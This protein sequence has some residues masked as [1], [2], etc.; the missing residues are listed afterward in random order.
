MANQSP[1]PGKRE[2]GYC[3]A[4]MVRDGTIV[5]LGTGSTVL[6]AMERLS[7]RIR[8]GFSVQ[9]V[10]TSYEAEIRARRFGIPLT[11][12]DEHPGIEVAI[13]GADQVDHELRMIKGRGAAH[14]REKCVAAAAAELIIVV[15]GSKLVTRLDAPV[16]IEVIPFALSPVDQAVKRM[17]GVTVLR[18]G[19]GKD[20]PVITDNG[21]FVLDCSFGTITDPE[22]LEQRLTALPGVLSC[23]LFTGFCEKTT[24][25]IG[26]A[27]KCRIVNS[28]KKPET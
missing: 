18:E 13:D 11:N 10:P 17:G 23:G 7:A 15:T 24:V 20:G 19:G 22:D 2:A 3:A 4:E 21:N 16:P 26:E 25:V 5:G 9:G 12:L 8:E 14:T 28:R 27:D 1:D 6:Y